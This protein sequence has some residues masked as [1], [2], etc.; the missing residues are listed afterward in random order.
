MGVGKQEAGLEK[1]EVLPGRLT[2]MDG[3]FAPLAH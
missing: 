3:E 2:A 1:I